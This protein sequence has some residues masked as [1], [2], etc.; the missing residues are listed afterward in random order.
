M[1][2]QVVEAEE[3]WSDPNRWAAWIDGFGHVEQLEGEWPQV[4]TRLLWDSRPRAAAGCPERVAA[5]SGG[6]GQTVDLE[7]SAAVRRRPS[8]S[9]PKAT[10]YE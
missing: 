1:P 2:G 7:D 4:G 6:G 8:R 5:S 9:S 10:R 3:L